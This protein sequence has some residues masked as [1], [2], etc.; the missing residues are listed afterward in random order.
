MEDPLLRV[1]CGSPV[2]CVEHVRSDYPFVRAIFI[3]EVQHLQ[4]AGLFVKGLVDAKLNLPIWVTGSSSFHLRGRTRE[5]LAGRAIRCQLL[6]FSL[7]ELLEHANPPN[8]IAEK[9]VC[10]QIVSHQ[11][12]WGSYPAIYLAA[13]RQKKMSLLNDL[14]EALI[15]RDASD[16]F[17]IKRVDAFRKLLALLA[18]QIGNLLNYSELASVC[19]VDGGTI[20]AYIEILE[21]SHVVKKVQPFAGGK[22]R[23]IIGTPKVFFIDNGIRNQLLYDFSTDLSLRTDRG[24]LVENWVFTEI[25]KAL[26]LQSAVKFWR[27]KARAEVD[28]VIEHAGYSYGVEVKSTSLERPKLSRS[29]RSFIEA[30]KPKQFAVVNMTLLEEISLDEAEVSFLTPSQLPSWLADLFGHAFRNRL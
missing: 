16:L 25:Y 26:P 19:N 30:Y 28:F 10:E 22:R 4:E 15:L 12:I 9:E 20:N 11:I 14:V 2:D 5:S 18:R 21:E 27:S 29:S 13:E 1:G 17:M 6:P 3:D 23:E 8:P 24:H 7:K